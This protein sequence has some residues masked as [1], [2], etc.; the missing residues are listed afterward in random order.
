MCSLK[1]SNPV[2]RL[3]D[4]NKQLLLLLLLLL[5]YL[6]YC[7][8]ITLVLTFRLLHTITEAKQGGAQGWI[9]QPGHLT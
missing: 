5:L 4:P 6:H 3:Q 8:Y 9:I 1:L 7:T 2:L